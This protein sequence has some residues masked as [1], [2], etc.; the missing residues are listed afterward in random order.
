MCFSAGEADRYNESKNT[1]TPANCYSHSL[2]MA[3]ARNMIVKQE[4]QTH[5]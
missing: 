3:L 1:A 5:C 2:P 4:M